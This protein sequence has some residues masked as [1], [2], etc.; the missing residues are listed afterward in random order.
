MR[1]PQLQPGT[2]YSKQRNINYPDGGDR[3]VFEGGW[4][5]LSRTVDEDGDEYLEIVAYLATEELA[6]KLL[7]SLIDCLYVIGDGVGDWYGPV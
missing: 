5:I 6:D 2:Y 7:M 4:A 1:E 3:E